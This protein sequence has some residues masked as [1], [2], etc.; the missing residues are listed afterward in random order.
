MTKNDV[1]IIVGTSAT[2]YPAASLPEIASKKGAKIFEVN[3]EETNFNELK[4]YSFLKGG[5]AKVLPKLLKVMKSL[6]Q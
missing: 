3:L 6:N 1:M 5:A 4:N 2:V